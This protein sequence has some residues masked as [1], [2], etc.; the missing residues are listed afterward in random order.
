MGLI[1]GVAAACLV[2]GVV[3]AVA[4]MKLLR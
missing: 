3:L 4:V 1:F 2:M